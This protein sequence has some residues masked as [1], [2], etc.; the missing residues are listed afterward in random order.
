MKVGRLPL[1]DC[2]NFYF[3]K[4]RM[5]Y[6]LMSHGLE[7]WNDDLN[8][9]NAPPTLPTDEDERKAYIAKEKALN[10][11]MSGITNFEFAKVLNYASAKEVWDKL[12][13]LYDG[14]GTITLINGKWMMKKILHHTSFE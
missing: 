13:S 12:V 14:K 7:V 4:K 10:S 9:Y 6:Y 2:T 8:G 3:W 5:S 1:F 11:I